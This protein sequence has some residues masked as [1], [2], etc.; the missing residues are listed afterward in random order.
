MIAKT[1]SSK[2]ALG[3]AIPG[4]QARQ[5]QVDM[6]EAV[7]EAIQQQTQLVVEAGT[8]NRQNLRLSGA[9]SSEW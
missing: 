1:F 4:F 9:S 3:K 5:P 2:G 8:G 7:A 6:A